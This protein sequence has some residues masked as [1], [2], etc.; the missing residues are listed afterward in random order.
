MIGGLLGCFGVGLWGWDNF[1]KGWRLFGAALIGTSWLLG[2]LGL[3]IWWV[4]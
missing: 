1:Y 2:S 4:V 3:I